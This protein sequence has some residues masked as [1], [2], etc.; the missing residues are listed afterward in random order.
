[1]EHILHAQPYT[2]LVLSTVIPCFSKLASVANLFTNTLQA[3]TCV[4]GTPLHFHSFFKHRIVL[5][6]T[7]PP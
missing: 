3:V 2:T 5:P 1:M 6:F 4:E 7:V